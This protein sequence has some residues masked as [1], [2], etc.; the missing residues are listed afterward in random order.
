LPEP[1]AFLRW[2]L[3]I[4]LTGATCAGLA[5]RLDVYT[6]PRVAAARRLLRMRGLLDS[7]PVVERIGDRLPFVKQLARRTSLSRLL[8]YT[9]QRYSLSRWVALTTG[10]A[11]LGLLLTSVVALA[12]ETTA[13]RPLVPLFFGPLVAIAL[14]GL[15]YLSLLR[16]SRRRQREMTLEMGD[17]LVSL[18]VLVGA[19]GLSVEDALLALSRCTRTQAVYSLLHDDAWQELIPSRPRTQYQLFIR[20]GDEY[21]V[22]AFRMLGEAVRAVTVKGLDPLAQYSNL[23]GSFY[24]ERLAEAQSAAAR[25]RIKLAI[26]VA[27]MI[28]PLLLLLTAPLVYSIV[29]GLRA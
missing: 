27:G 6:P 11:L 29:N 12:A 14:V 24:V 13:G 22:P 15:A 3:L 23:A 19:G 7:R 8:A 21:E 1:F 9:G 5:W 26:P 10:L 17:M 16:K 28:L 2:P 4:A 25:A 18:G 20:I